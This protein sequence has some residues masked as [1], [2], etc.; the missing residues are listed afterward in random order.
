MRTP[1]VCARENEDAEEGMTRMRLHG[2]RRL[3]VVN[4]DGQLTGIVTMDDLL[5]L[6]AADANSLIEIV[7]KEQDHEHRTC[8]R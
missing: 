6:I 5:K 3:P 7:R 4:A 1:I 8:C 2:V